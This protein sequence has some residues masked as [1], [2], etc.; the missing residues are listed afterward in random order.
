MASKES[1]RGSGEHGGTAR[2]LKIITVIDEEKEGDDDK[3]DSDNGDGNSDDI[4]DDNGDDNGDED[5]DAYLFK[6]C[7]KH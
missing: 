1:R 7:L 2:Q 6:F 3:S 4:G 5:G